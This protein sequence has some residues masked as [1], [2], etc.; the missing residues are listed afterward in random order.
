MC[1]GWWGSGPGLGA[2][3]GQIGLIEKNL[4]SSILR[5]PSENCSKKLTFSCQA[6]RRGEEGGQLDL[7]QIE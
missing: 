2:Y 4:L 1:G 7:S 6:D 5:V 3:L